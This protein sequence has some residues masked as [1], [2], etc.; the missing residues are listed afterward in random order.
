MGNIRAALGMLGALVVLV[1]SLCRAELAVAQVAQPVGMQQVSGRI[2]SVDPKAKLVKVEAEKAIGAV[3]T[4]QPMEF[5]LADT[6]VITEGVRM[7]RPEELRVGRNVQIEYTIEQGRHI[8]QLISV[9]APNEGARLP[10]GAA[11]P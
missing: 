9:Q 6:T 11:A 3:S 2:Q 10:E 7:L 8:A 5:S 4:S 1:G